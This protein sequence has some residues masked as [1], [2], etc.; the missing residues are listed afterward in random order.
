M[1]VFFSLFFCPS[2]IPPE[3]L[4]IAQVPHRVTAK[5]GKPPTHQPAGRVKVLSHYTEG[6]F[7]RTRYVGVPRPPLC[8]IFICCN[9]PI[10]ATHLALPLMVHFHLPPPAAVQGPGVNDYYH[11]IIARLQ[12]A[13][14]NHGRGRTRIS[15]DER[16]ASLW[17]WLSGFALH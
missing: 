6:V 14:A 7:F 2:L 17:R 16:P 10:C 1:S 8:H 13:G 11:I 9:T 4:S 15:A 5:K 12:P 3:V